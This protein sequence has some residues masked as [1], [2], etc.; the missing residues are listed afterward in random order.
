MDHLLAAVK[1]Q[2]KEVKVLSGVAVFNLD[3]ENLETIPYEPDHLLD[4]DSW[5]SVSDFKEQ[6]YCLDILKGEFISVEYNQISED[7]VSDI[8]YLCSYEGGNF[9]FQKISP[10]M[11]LRNRKFLEFGEDVKYE[12]SKEMI[13]IKDNPDAIYIVD[14]DVLIFKNLS[15]ISSMFKGIDL[16]YKEATTEEVQE[17]LN[18]PFLEVSDNFDVEKVS[19][20]NRKR[21]GLAQN[22]LQALNDEEKDSIVEYIKEYCAEKVPYD[23][24]KGAFSVSNDKDLKLIIY[25]IEQRFYTTPLKP[26][27]RLAN[28]I[29]K[30]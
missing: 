8:K 2:R 24:E 29:L 16:L 9:L 19:V 23:E 27:R 21:I 1:R 13:V 10:S 18:E 17:F 5:F 4:E 7:K 26:E 30:L 25:G 14:D 15:T 6:E 11:F 20:H 28:S 12:D 22:T 3:Y